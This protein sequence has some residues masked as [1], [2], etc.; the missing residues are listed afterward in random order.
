MTVSFGCRCGKSKKVS[1]TDLARAQTA[2]AGRLGCDPCDVAP[3]VQCSCG[4][5][6]YTEGTRLPQLDV[7]STR[8]GA[9]FS[10]DQFVVD[11]HPQ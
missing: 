5:L 1:K 8:S 6:A 2:H 11:E 10:A 7:E 9:T 3:F 4:K